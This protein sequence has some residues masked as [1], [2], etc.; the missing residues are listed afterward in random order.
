[1]W[2]RVVL[3]RHE[4]VR[5]SAEEVRADS[6]QLGRIQVTREP[7][8]RLGQWARVALLDIGPNL[9][10]ALHDVTLT[11]WTERGLVLAGVER[12]WSRKSC[13][14]L[15]QAWW[16]R[17]EVGPVVQPLC[18]PVDTEEEREQLEEALTLA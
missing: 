17:P 4:G 13:V 11:R 2:V 15:P 1:M 16:C 5:R 10:W 9:V 18:D 6:G 3:L 12:R 14:Q 7:G 8:A